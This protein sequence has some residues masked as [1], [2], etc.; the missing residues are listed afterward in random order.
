MSEINIKPEREYLHEI[1]A[2]IR[3]G[4]YAI[5]AFQRE[6]VWRKEQVLELFDSI[7]SGYPIGSV[8]MWKPMQEPKLK[9]RNMLTDV[10]YDAE[11]T[12]PLYANAE[13]WQTNPD[14]FILDGRQRL[15]AFFGCI[16][17]FENKRDEFCLFYNLRVEEFVY[18]PKNSRKKTDKLIVPLNTLYDTFRLLEYLQ[19][20]MSQYTNVEEARTF[21]NRARSLN[22]RLQSVQIAETMIENCALSEAGKVFSRINSTGTDISDVAMLQ[23]VLYNSENSILLG[24]RLNQVISTLGC[25]SFDSLKPDD[26]L[27]CCYRYV[28]RKF[29]DSNLKNIK[30]IDFTPY[31][32]DIDRD[33][34]RTV[35]FLYQRCHVCNATL[36]PYRRQFYLLAGFFKEHQQPDEWQLE[37]LERWFYYTTIQRSFLNS[38]L[39]VVRSQYDDFEQFICGKSRTPT[40]YEPIYLKEINWNFGFS[41]A[42][43]LSDFIVIIQAENYRRCKPSC[44]I[45]LVGHQCFPQTNRIM[46]AIPFFSVSDR[47]SFAEWI[48]GKSVPT[49]E[50]L[51]SMVLTPQLLLLIQNQTFDLYCSERQKL[52]LSL[53]ESKLSR[54]GIQVVKEQENAEDFGE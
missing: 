3:S 10:L 28:R 32:D 49:T 33:V 51:K 26:I 27:N 42:A 34:R 52:I 24:E 48:T 16:S 13:K 46:A 29:F 17:D 45:D 44:P 40:N 35:E 12:L 30:G 36:L 23:A 14:Y 21:I 20:I 19:E 39:S 31:L 11:D 25:Y 5:P 50:E 41:L 43:A 54:I 18:L 37:E 22:S 47:S 8:L 7:K 9:S 15:S 38:S 53:V 2:K 6:F 4:I 1:V